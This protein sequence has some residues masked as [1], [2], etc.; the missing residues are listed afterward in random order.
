[1]N[2]PT[3]FQI[4]YPLNKTRKFWKKMVERLLLIIPYSLILG[5]FVSSLF[6]VLTILSNQ[7]N[8]VFQPTNFILIN[9][10]LFLSFFIILTIIYSVYYK[11]YIKRYYYDCG[12]DFITIKKNV[13]TPTEIHVQY[14]KIQDVYV[15]QDLLDRIFG[16][17]DVH[18]ASATITSGI[19]AHIDGVNQYVAESLK[20]IILSKIKNVG[21][22]E[23][24]SQTPTQTEQTP[25]FQSDKK[26]SSS[27]Y[28]ISSLWIYSVMA[29]IAFFDLFFFAIALASTK[30]LWLALLFYALIFLPIIWGFSIWKR[31]Y[32]FEFMPDYIL[33]HTS[34]ISK[35]EKHMPYKAIQNINNVQSIFDRMFGL[36][37]VIIE[38]ASN[39]TI[40]RGGRQYTIQGGISLVWQPKEKAEELAKILNDIVSKI[41]PQNTNDMMGL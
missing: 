27:T 20:N 30:T 24:N 23:S 41:N 25:Q 10:M 31:N 26:I 6:P 32:Y 33:L 11:A 38:N 39:Q 12:A 13:F 7:N 14:Q 29:S 22:P 4:Q 21:N 3:A 2:Q 19:E 17:Y 8:V 35:E 28:P 34:L 18:I 9:L 36:S 1:M 40:S 16:L 15:D 37:K 5:I